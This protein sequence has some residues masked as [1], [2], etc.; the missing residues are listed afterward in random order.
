[1]KGLMPHSRTASPLCSSEGRNARFCRENLLSIASTLARLQHSMGDRRP[2]R[3]DS[4]SSLE[5]RFSQ[6]Q[7]VFC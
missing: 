5:I 4:P 7:D 2:K 6:A 3:F 1:M